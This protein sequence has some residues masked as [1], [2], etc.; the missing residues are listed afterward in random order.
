MAMESLGITLTNNV[1][2]DIIEVIRSIKDSRDF[3]ERNF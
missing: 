1:I 2:K 3:K